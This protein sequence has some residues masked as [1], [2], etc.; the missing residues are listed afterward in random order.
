MLVKLTVPY[1]S[2]IDNTNV[3]KREKYSALVNELKEAG[4]KAK[5]FPVEVG[6]RGFVTVFTYS[7]T[8]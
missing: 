5:V 6:A 7:L 4:Y 2:R 3:F 8:Q 1:E